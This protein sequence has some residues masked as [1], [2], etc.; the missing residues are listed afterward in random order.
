MMSGNWVLSIVILPAPY[1]LIFS[2]QYEVA[3]TKLGEDVK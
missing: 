1:P 3:K 2:M